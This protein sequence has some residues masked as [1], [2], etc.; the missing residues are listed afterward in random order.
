M[1]AEARLKIAG[2]LADFP[3]AL[4]RGGQLVVT[5]KAKGVTLDYA[6]GWA[7]LT[8][9]DAD[10][11]IDGT[12]LTV[13]G[14]RG[15]V[16]GVE[17]GKT[18]AEIADLAT[19]VPL[20]RIIGEA[21][22]PVTGFARY[23][24]DRAVAARTGN[25]ADGIEATGNGQLALRLALPLG[26]PD[27]I[28]ISGDFTVA[29]AQL[30]IAGAPHLSKV[31]G[32]LAFTERD[33]RA[34]D[35]A[36]EV[37]G[38]PARITIASADGPARVTG[39]GTVN[40]AV[41]R[42]EFAVPY[43][44]RVSGTVDWTIGG[45][46]AAGRVDMGAREHDEG[47]GRRSAGAAGQARGRRDAAAH[48]AARRRGA[49]RRRFRHGHLRTRR[50][51]RRA[52]QARRH[53]HHG[54][55]RAAVAGSRAVDRPDAA[56]ADRPGMWI[57]AELPALNL[58]DWF[59]L[60]GSEA[61]A[62]AQRQGPAFAG[63]D[64]DVGQ[65]D[66]FGARFRDIKLRIRE[67][68]GGWQVDLDGPSASGTATWSAPGHR[69]SQRPDRR[70]ARAARHPGSTRLG[71]GARRGR[72]GRKRR[73]E[74]GGGRGEPVARDRRRGG[75]TAVQGPRR[76]P[77][78]VRRASA[79]H[80]MADRRL[81]LANDGG[82]IDADGQ[83][84]VAGRQQQT[85]LDVALDVKDAGTFLARIGYPDAVQNA[86]T[87][88]DGQLEWAGAP[89]D[90]DYPTLSGTFRIDVGPGRFTKIEPG[91]GKLLGVLSLQSLP[92]RI[93]LDFT[94]VFSE[95]F[96]FDEITGDVRIQSGAMTTSNLKLV[97]PA[98]KV[99]I[100]GDADLAQETQ[101]LSV[102]VQ[103]ALSSSVS[104]GAAL[105]FLA[106]P[107]VGAAIGAGSLLAQKVLKDPIEQ[108]FSYEYQ[109]TGSWSDPVVTR[110]VRGER[111]RAARGRRPLP[112]RGEP[113]RMPT[114]RSRAMR[115]A[116]VQ[117]VSGGDVAANLA[118]AEPL[119]AAA[120]A[121][122]ARLVVLPEYFGILGARATDKLAVREADGDGPA[123]GVAGR[124]AREHGICLVG[125]T[126]PLACARPDRVR[127]ACL[128]YGPDGARIARYDK[129][130][131]F[132]FERG[133][134][135]YDEGRTI[136][137]GTR[138]RDLRRALRARRPV[139]L[140]RP[141]VSRALS[142][143]GRARADPRAVGVHRDDRRRALAP[144]AARARRRE[145][146][147]R[148]RRGAG[149][150]ASQW[151][152]HLRPFAADRPVGRDRRRAR[153]RGPGHRRRRRRSGAPRRSPRTAARAVAPRV[154]RERFEA[155]PR[156][157]PCGRGSGAWSP[158]ARR[159]MA[160]MGADRHVRMLGMPLTAR[161]VARRP[162][163][164]KAAGPDPLAFAACATPARNAFAHTCRA[165]RPRSRISTAP[166]PPACCGASQ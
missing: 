52:P 45:R 47:R 5:A 6:D 136:E 85:K 155:D 93:T 151:A 149:R 81:A 70:A 130:H 112:R 56:R 67:S 13:D 120:A 65:L 9:I 166:P 59:A 87:R 1:A 131:L 50:A 141:A 122:G 3:F 116:A 133:D 96:A 41:L 117:T 91:I 126:V 140:L 43:L 99:E 72:Q 29:D 77:A 139:G 31:N 63:A 105:L 62:D 102:R 55:S 95:G 90:F 7:P 25:I 51:A 164:R 14:T 135:R 144:A 83:W 10:V 68:Q 157:A 165:Y 2:N 142:R 128:V 40:L 159:G 138:R 88:I 162:A 27:E 147:L 34:R 163:L 114:A 94:D 92:R 23:V 21:A 60:T 58:D 100:S 113:I 24:S 150:R 32:T 16:Y 71:A 158:L 44:D 42:R 78:R 160:M 86:P 33:V 82:R 54:R 61:T 20:L 107:L 46:R 80:R 148:A 97:G 161:S 12:R 36:V 98:A 11:R 18:R 30:R 129:I 109:V 137:P 134:E 26:H 73:V 8:D 115:V 69:G 49:G 19:T 35:V 145:P 143:A 124:L 15:R 66:V 28:R 57:R 146:V 38:G 106:N 119:I 154:L 104:A 101:Q 110:S 76:R 48:R 74:A 37:L 89:H 108:M 111:E 153:I 17:I 118:Q 156:R 127:S 79:R 4:G 132:A 152:A 84:R 39:S 64:L 121:Q 75:R 123:A 53:G 22:G 103:P 125:G